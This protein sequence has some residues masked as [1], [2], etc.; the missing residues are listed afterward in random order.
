MKNLIE[1]S[2]L[3]DENCANVKADGTR[4]PMHKSI[5]VKIP[6]GDCTIYYNI[7]RGNG[8]SE[9]YINMQMISEYHHDTVKSYWKFYDDNAKFERA[10]KRIERKV[11][12][13]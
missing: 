1:Q 7:S 6:N 12:S 10:I 13:V 4:I 11:A 8:I 3:I 2:F 5:S 9:S